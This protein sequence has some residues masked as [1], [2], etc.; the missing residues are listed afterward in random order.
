MSK[1]NYYDPVIY[2]STSDN[3]YTMGASITLKEAIDG[4]LLHKSVEELRT[5]YPYFYIRPKYEDN[6][7]V[8]EH[9]PLPIVIRN[10][11][12]PIKLFSKEANYHF[13]SIKYEGNRLA[14]EAVHS[15]SDGAGFLPYIKSLLFCYLTH[16]TGEKF[17]PD[18][19]RLPNTTIKDAE[20]SNP[21]NDNVIDAVQIDKP[22]N[23]EMVD[24]YKLRENISE[25]KNNWY[26]FYLE[27]PENEF[28]KFCK[29]NGGTPNIAFSTFLAKAI[30]NVNPHTNK[31]ITVSVALD[32]KSI[33]GNTENYRSFPYIA[34][35]NFSKEAEHTNL[36]DIF[37]NAKEQLSFQASPKSISYYLKMLKTGFEQMKPLPLQNK[38]SLTQQSVNKQIS[39]VAVSYAKN[40]SFGPLDSYI[41]EIYYLAEPHVIDLICEVA[42]I[43]Q[44]FFLSFI[45]NFS[46][47]TIFQAFLKE[48]E[49]V[50]IS[51]KIKSK[52]LYRPSG[53]R[54][55]GID[56]VKL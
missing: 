19:F 5:R 41:Q 47:E 23:I 32:C 49:S 3:P 4:S 31:N 45:Q 18:G 38:I 43:N 54:Y 20:I 51:Y 26:S 48:L 9:N 46:S 10:S 40:G 11:W 15:I 37:K 8:V 13:M 29:E 7:L 53:V 34:L 28:I 44:S 14:I 33:M 39:T 25:E 1:K 35:L 21:F 2:M 52:E 24:F 22:L 30:R 12:E 50:G 16:K 17:E 42:C 27:L 36:K 55:D 6:D 56:N